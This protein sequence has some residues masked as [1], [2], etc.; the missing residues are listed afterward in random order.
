MMKW[1][2]LN[3]DYVPNPFPLIYIPLM[4][5]K[6]FWVDVSYR[7]AKRQLEFIL[8]IVQLLILNHL[9]IEKD[10]HSFILRVT[11]IFIGIL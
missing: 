1:L 5:N 3:I 11:V 4:Y 6:D 8:S 9:I 10:M 7:S 2:V